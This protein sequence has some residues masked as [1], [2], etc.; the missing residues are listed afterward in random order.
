MLTAALSCGSRLE[1]REASPSDG[2]ERRGNLPGGSLEYRAGEAGKPG[3]V[4]GYAAI[5]GAKATELRWFTEEI[6][7]GAFTESLTKRD[8][9]ALAHHDWSKPL[10]RRSAGSLKLSEDEKGLKVEFALPDTSDGRD[11]DVNIRNG[12]VKGFSFGMA[13]EGEE[14]SFAK[15]KG[16]LDHRAV[17]KADLYEV[18]PVTMPAYDASLLSMAQRSLEK[19]KAEAKPA[20]DAVSLATRKAQVACLELA[21]VSH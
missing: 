20:G 1:L 14:W 8:Q 6:R 13:V 15:G 21:E 9:V 12:N 18:S 19:A 5:W 4:T 3:T 10:A 11:L 2:V 17:T 7:K 16:E